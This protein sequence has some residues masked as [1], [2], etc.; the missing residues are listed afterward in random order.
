VLLKNVSH[1]RDIVNRLVGTSGTMS[2]VEEDSD[3]EGTMNPLVPREEKEKKKKKKSK[4]S[5]K[6]EK[7]RDEDDR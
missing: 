7:D 6:R 2:R 3:E 1:A 5:S 4:K